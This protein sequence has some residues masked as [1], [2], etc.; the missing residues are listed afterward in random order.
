MTLLVL[1]TGVSPYERVA[2]NAVLKREILKQGR[3]LEYVSLGENGVRSVVR[4]GGLSRG[5]G[6]NVR[7]WV[8]RV[9]G[10][11]ESVG[12]GEWREELGDG[13]C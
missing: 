2:P 13:L 9:V 1:V 10:D 12:L 7:K 5:L 3:P 6:F 11:G 8:G 4:L